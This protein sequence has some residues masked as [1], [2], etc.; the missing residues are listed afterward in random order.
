MLRRHLAPFVLAA[1]PSF[2]IG[3]GAC[4]SSSGGAAT[5]NGPVAR[6]A[7]VDGTTPNMLD[8]PFPSDVYRDATGHLGQV[9]GLDAL[10]RVGSE[11]LTHE[12]LHMD[13]FSR[14]AMSL[15]YV[16]DPAA[17][18]TEDGDVAAALIDPTSL[19]I[20]EK[21]CAADASS[22]FLL[23]LAASDPSKMRVACRAEWHHDQSSKARSLV[24]VGPA[25][26][27]VLDE[28]HAY[29][30]VITSRVKDTKGHAIAAS[31]AFKTLRDGSAAGVYRQPLDA[32]KA[33]LASALASD[34]SEIVAIAPF[35]TNAMTKELFDLREELEDA[36]AATLKW[37]AASMAPMGAVRFAAPVGGQLPAGFTASLDDWFGV[38]DASATLPDGS[39]DPDSSLPV[40]AHDKIAVV[41]TGMFDAVNYL[42]VK[43]DGYATL[44][45]ATFARDGSGK[46]V[47]APE[48]PTSKIWVTIALPTAPMPADGYPV[49]IVQ[50]GLSSSRH[51]VPVLANLF[52]TKGWAVVGIDSVT[53]G[54]RAPEPVYQVD[55]HSDYESAPGAKYK[56]PDGIGDADAQGNRNGSTDLFGSLKNIGAIRDQFRQAALDTTQLVKLVRSSALDLSGVQTGA[57][58]PKF[59]AA[60]VAYF[61]DSLGGIQGAVAAAIE[62][63]VKQWAFNVP[64]G[65]LLIELSAHSPTLGA[66]L[67]LAAGAN[68]GLNE[69]S[70][71][72][73][74]PLT[75][76]IQLIADPGDPINYAS[77]LIL[78]PRSIKGAAIAP[79]NILQFEVVYDEIVSNEANE[80][81]ARAG[82]WGFATPNVGSNSGILDFKNL[83]NNHARVPLVDETPDGMMLFH[84]TPVMGSTAIIV[85]ASPAQHG[86]DFVSSTGSRQ[87][88]IPYADFDGPQPFHHIDFGSGFSI[89]SPYRALQATTVQFFDD[90]FQGKVPT[91]SV[92]KAPIRDLDD[93]GATDDVD[94]DP[95]NPKVK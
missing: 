38:V 48:K 75:N 8:V 50:H 78:H 66:L 19:P 2:V 24:A 95:A 65:G 40:R 47:P 36:P 20:D 11:Y 13:G 17:P 54:A 18:Q 3:V 73:S 62:P 80:A 46:I 81:L 74:H 84:D 92:L 82:G 72:Q 52:C 39:D 37:D 1:L 12:F 83:A 5:T 63:N 94:A 71:D 70:L 88:G 59:D 51:Y 26:G 58:P 28:A 41:A 29:V 44:D 64:G 15:F 45:H 4:S 30:T 85:Q 23:D 77:L 55:Q 61:G 67:N 35:T 49:V 42:Q 57:T 60:R 56:G 68:F 16:D 10:F 21:A 93:D 14:I 76:L 91:V 33:A 79:R 9:P 32:A 6:F 87:F 34:K 27:I 89:R 22:V 90:G 25:R 31:A 7:L 53:F 86:S 69:N 43:P